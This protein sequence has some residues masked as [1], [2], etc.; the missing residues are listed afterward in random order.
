[1]ASVDIFQLYGAVL[2]LRV[3]GSKMVTWPKLFPIVTSSIRNRHKNIEFSASGN[4]SPVIVL[5]RYPV[6][7]SQSAR[8]ANRPERQWETRV[9]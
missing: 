2:Y 1:M 6:R 5:W 4:E 8:G 3:I 7:V 9:Y